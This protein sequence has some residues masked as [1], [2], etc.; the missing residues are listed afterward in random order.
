M[1]TA[2]HQTYAASSATGQ[3]RQVGPASLLWDCI[4]YLRRAVDR[5]RTRRALL[6][7]DAHLLRDIG[8]SRQEALAEAGKPFWK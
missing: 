8:R 4:M 7:L 3:A 5:Q 1:I 2:T 6:D